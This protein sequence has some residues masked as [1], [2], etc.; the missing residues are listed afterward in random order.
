MMNDNQSSIGELIKE[1]YKQHHRENAFEEMKVLESWRSVVGDFISDHT[2][3]LRI[4]RNILYVKVDADSLRNEL[5]YSR[6]SLLNNLNKVAEM[7][8]LKDIVFI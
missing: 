4:V 1:F 6:T 8:L 7:E 5:I 3:D 2:L